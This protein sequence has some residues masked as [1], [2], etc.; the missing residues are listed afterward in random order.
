M[1]LHDLDLWWGRAGSLCWQ[2][3][4][5]WGEG[6]RGRGCTQCGVRPH[7]HLQVRMLAQMPVRWMFTDNYKIG[8]HCR[9]HA[10]GSSSACLTQACIHVACTQQVLQ[11]YS[12]LY[13][14]P[15]VS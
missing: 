4:E 12:M 2:P 7:C 5:G 9:I 10:C 1:G 13:H 6:G 3:Q 8:M 15:S 14:V 11:R